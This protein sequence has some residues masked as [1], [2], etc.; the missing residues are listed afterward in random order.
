MATHVKFNI[1]KFWD[2]EFKNLNYVKEKFNDPATEIAW[3]DA[4]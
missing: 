3:Q 2:D 1:A 4:G